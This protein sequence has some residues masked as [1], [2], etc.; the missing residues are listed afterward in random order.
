MSSKTL[1]SETNQGVTMTNAQQLTHAQEFF[2]GGEW[3]A[4]HSAE[5]AEVIDPSTELSVETPARGEAA[6]VDA[7]VAAAR[8]AFPAYAETTRE[9]RLALLDNILA[10]Y[11]ARSEEIA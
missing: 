11:D 6:A 4:P 8:A 7:A 3:V 5:T 10:V 9:E 2:I 1:N